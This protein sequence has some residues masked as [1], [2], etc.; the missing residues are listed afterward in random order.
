MTLDELR[1]WLYTLVAEQQVAADDAE[2]LLAA[3]ARLDELR[4]EF[5]MAWPAPVV[6]VAGGELIT[7][8]SVVEML[9]RAR[10]MDALVYFERADDG[11]GLDASVDQQPKIDL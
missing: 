3:R 5:E 10:Q 11:L 9:G 7:T 8:S 6:G 2:E 1:A 4:P